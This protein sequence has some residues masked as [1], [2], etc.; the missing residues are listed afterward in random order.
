M[1]NNGVSK[2]LNLAPGIFIFC[3]FSRKL[4]DISVLSV[5]SCYITSQIHSTLGRD[6]LINTHSNRH[7]SPPLHLQPW[8]YMSASEY[9]FPLMHRVYIDIIKTNSQG[10]ICNRKNDCIHS[11]PLSKPKV[12]SGW[13]SKMDLPFTQ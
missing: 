7:L 10:E 4:H 11:F 5:L 9:I 2:L 6:P 8:K 12:G 1:T 13:F 3:I